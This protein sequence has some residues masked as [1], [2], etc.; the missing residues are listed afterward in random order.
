MNPNPLEM[1]VE[2]RAA[3]FTYWHTNFTRLGIIPV[4]SDDPPGVIW[5]PLSVASGPAEVNA[6]EKLGTE[7]LAYAARRRATL[8]GLAPAPAPAPP[9]AGAPVPPSEREI[10]SASLSAEQPSPE[11]LRI[12]ELEEE[13]ARMKQLM[14]GEAE[15][16]QFTTPTPGERRPTPVVR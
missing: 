13:L 15:P 1:T 12:T 16:H 5:F 14:G 10:A 11:D 3:Q 4:F 9:R 6:C 7:L 8:A 2:D